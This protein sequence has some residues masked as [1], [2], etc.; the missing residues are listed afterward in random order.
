MIDSEIR[1]GDKIGRFVVVGEL[2]AGGMGVVFEAHDRELDRRVAL[3]VLRGGSASEEER[4]R[5]LREGQAMARITHP[6]V[7]T[8][9]EVGVADT[10]VFLAQEL[11]DG[12]NLASWLRDTRSQDDIIAK[13]VAAGRGLAAAHAAGLVHRDFKPD[14]VLLGKDGRVRVADFGLAR[15]LGAEEVILLTKR[16]GE[17]PASS[18]HPMSP[19]TRT[20][21][22]MGTPMYMAPE[23]HEGEPVDERTDQ[24]SFCVALYHALYGD[25]PFA[26]KTSV[27]LADNV[28]KGNVQK[29]PKR[30]P[31]RLR[32]I[33]LR[34]LA[35]KPA[36]RYPSMEV[37]LDELTRQPSR[38]LQRFA[39]VAG[40]AIVVGGAV[41]GGVVLSRSKQTPPPPPPVAKVDTKDLSN[42]KATEWLAS[43]ME[44]GQ[45]DDALEKYDMAAALK[46]QQ[47]DRVQSSIA[48]AIGGY[49]QVLRGE[50]AGAEKRVREAT[51]AAGGDPI[52]I[53]YVDL[54]T[55]ARA[56]AAGELETAV[57]RGRSCA[58]AFKPTIPELAAL[59]HQLRGE[60]EA[61]RGDD[62]ASGKAY[63]SAR[64]LSRKHPDRLLAIELAHA[65]LLLDLGLDEKAA[66]EAL[67]LQAQA[68][69]RSA[70]T[71]E[72]LATVIL[73]RVR[74]RQGESSA[75]LELLEHVKP[76]T[77]QDLRIKL[78]HAIA[79]G[80][81]LAL[82]SDPEGIDRIETARRDA[83][84]RGFVGLALEARL[85]RLEVLFATDDKQ[86]LAE[87]RTLVADA[88]KHGYG[89]V[90]KLAQ[91]V[92]QR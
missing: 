37:L 90:A 34:G 31:S 70:V 27:A 44:R 51:A 78:L 6:N 86:L 11:L 8:V 85:A 66:T 65:E 29:P 16:A 21:A 89:R 18:P 12:G 3:K 22:V 60:A 20:G 76:A 23:Q 30:I 56:L 62:A 92:A 17:L 33:L 73:A 69:E 39:L 77:L 84:K 72:A 47:G 43:A 75:A 64:E 13:F 5:M 79:H 50:L 59:C 25:W 32:A 45:L 80:Q 81:A 83:D 36:D 74:L 41:V 38:K 42:T 49:T 52:A 35:V 9:Y 40:A 48:Y 82:Q 61:D 58:A 26:G 88:E 24:F 55:A 19:L 15:A 71:G 67:A 14:N 46:L 53:A 2:G 57:A 63:A 10:G 4:V 87:Q 68:G 54:A 1:Y 7:I 28:L 91:T